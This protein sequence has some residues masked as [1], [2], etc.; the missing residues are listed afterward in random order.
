MDL[1]KCG[2]CFKWLCSPDTQKTCESCRIVI[3]DDCNPSCKSGS[4]MICNS[5]E[6]DDECLCGTSCPLCRGVCPVQS[7]GE[8]KSC[9]TCQG[10]GPC[11]KCNKESGCIQH[12]D[13]FVCGICE[14]SFGLCSSHAQELIK[15]KKVLECKDAGHPAVCEECTKETGR[16]RKMRCNTC[17]RHRR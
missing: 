17:E 8:L 15:G 14:K 4:H 10:G 7:C 5:C 2:T 12:A 1:L 16:K 9:I 3:C 13:S 6:Q 11:I